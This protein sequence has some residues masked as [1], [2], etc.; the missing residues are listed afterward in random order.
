MTESGDF[1]LAAR[2]NEDL[3]KMA[4]EQTA[5]TLNKVLLASSEGMRNGYNRSDN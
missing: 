4:R 1:S 2:A 5:D 3:A